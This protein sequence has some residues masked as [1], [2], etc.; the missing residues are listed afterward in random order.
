MSV[1]SL[2][3]ACLWLV[4]GCQGTG[5]AATPPP[6][7]AQPILDPAP[8]TTSRVTP[9][10]APTARPT[11]TAKPRRPLVALD[12]G[13]GGEDLGARHF[14]LNGQMDFH[15]STINLQL[16]QRIGNKLKAQGYRVFYTR[17][18]DYL[19]NRA[20]KDLNGDGELTPHDDLLLRVD[21]VN[22]ARADLLLSL[23]QNAWEHPDDELV[24]ATGGT[25]T[26]YCP[27]RTFADRNLRFAN[28]VHA[29][30]LA[31]VRR[32][33]H[34]P[35]D[36]GVLPDHSLAA[37]GDAARHLMI[38]GPVDRVIK[39]ASQMP[40]VLSEPLFITCDVEAALMVREDFQEALADAY[41]R[42][43][44]AYFAEQESP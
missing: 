7:T 36:R 44:V 20:Q 18:G 10:R 40:G 6:A 22:R 9:S 8:A 23:H 5:P 14:D 13:H 27:D 3:G 35:T 37:P 4:C 16:A 30:V 34:E 42:A 25:T 41:V 2:V 26:Y 11:P 32:F 28:L 15:E 31:T 12:P 39:R 19:P 43:I 17:D 38:L 29:E 21:L 33:G 1:L 24:R